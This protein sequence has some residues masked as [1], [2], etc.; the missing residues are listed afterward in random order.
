MTRFGIEV[1][2]AAGRFFTNIVP[3][4]P[5]RE[6]AQ[7]G[8]QRGRVLGRKGD[9]LDIAVPVD[10]VLCRI[11]LFEYAVE[12]AAAESERTDRRAAGMPGPRQP[13][14]RRGV[15]VKRRIGGARAGQS[16]D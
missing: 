4:A 14:P 9:D 12:V 1:Q 11:G 6:P 7:R 2:S 15:Q 13:G 5:A 3:I 8:R 10:A 16:A